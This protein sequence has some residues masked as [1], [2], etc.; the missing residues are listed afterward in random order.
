MEYLLLIASGAVIGF[1]VAAPIGPVNLICIRRTLSFGPVNGLI[2]GVGAA[3]G[4]G[5]FAG[6]TAF[7]MT[8]VSELIKGHSTLLQIFGGALLL[9]FGISTYISDPLHGRGI[10]KAAARPV[11]SALPKSMKRSSPVS[12]AVKLSESIR[13]P[14]GGGSVIA[15]RLRRFATSGHANRTSDPG[16]SS[17]QRPSIAA[18]LAG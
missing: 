18:I 12:A 17:F 4:D 1:M 7:G 8:A 3:L 6:I 10:E 15:N 5:I 2:A 11:K 13:L 16:F 14:K 9:F